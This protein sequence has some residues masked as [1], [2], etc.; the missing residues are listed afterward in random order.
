MENIPKISPKQI[1]CYDKFN[2]LLKEGD[3]VDVQKDGVHQIYL[4]EDNQL[5]FK[6]Y[7]KEDRVCS[8]FSNDMVKCDIDGNWLTDDIYEKISEPRKETVEEAAIKASELGEYDRSLESVRKNYFIKGAKWQ[9][10]RSCTY[11]EA[12]AIWYAGQEYWKTSGDSITFEELIEKLLN[13]KQ[14]MVF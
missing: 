4:K 11:E 3:Y 7:G 12:R 5:Y 6:P 13:Q 1:E 9:E 14:R 10:E 8:Y 2:Q